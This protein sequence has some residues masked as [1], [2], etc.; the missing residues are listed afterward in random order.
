MSKLPAHR[1]VDRLPESVRTVWVGARRQQSAG[2][3]RVAVADG[4]NELLAE[5][6]GVRRLLRRTLR[7]ECR[8]GEQ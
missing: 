6:L 2:F 5:R 3:F 8:V 7:E 1:L 4:F